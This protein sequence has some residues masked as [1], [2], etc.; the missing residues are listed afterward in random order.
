MHINHKAAR[1]RWLN[2]RIEEGGYPF[3]PPK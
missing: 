2:K 3:H 1:Q